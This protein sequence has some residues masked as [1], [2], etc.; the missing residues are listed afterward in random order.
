MYI[1]LC[2]CVCV[3]QVQLP[4]GFVPLMSTSQLACIE[5]K[6]SQQVSSLVSFFVQLSDFGFMKCVISNK[7]GVIGDGA[8]LKAAVAR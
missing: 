1:S 2:V 6:A 5:L 4:K 7:K 8:A 3:E